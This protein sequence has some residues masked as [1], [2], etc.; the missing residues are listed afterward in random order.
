MN[1]DGH[2][3]EVVNIAIGKNAQDNVNED[4]AVE[5]GSKQMKSLKVVGLKTL[6]TISVVK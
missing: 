3:P 4:K 1:A 5:F 6:M 2:P